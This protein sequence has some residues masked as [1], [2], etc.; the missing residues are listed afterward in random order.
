MD[1]GTLFGCFLD[2][3]EAPML[4][5]TCKPSAAAGG[6]HKTC[7]SPFP[8][9]PTILKTL[10]IVNHYPKDPDIL[11]TVRVVNLVPVVNLLRVVIHY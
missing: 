5:C 4:E 8:K 7:C 11:K 2:M 6:M 3:V 10:R 9:D 1:S